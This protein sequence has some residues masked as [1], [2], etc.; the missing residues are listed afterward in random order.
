MGT[1][2]TALT[3]DRRDVARELARQVV[4][5]TDDELEKRRFDQLASAHFR[6][7]WLW[8]AR[9]ANKFDPTGAAG[10]FLTPVVLAVATALLGAVSASVVARLERNLGT[11]R[12]HRRRAGEPAAEAGPLRTPERAGPDAAEL[13]RLWDI[14]LAAALD[15]QTPEDHARRVAD[16]MLAKFVQAVAG[17]S[18]S[19]SSSASSSTSAATPS[20]EAGAGAAAPPDA[21]ADGAPLPQVLR[22]DRATE[23]GAPTGER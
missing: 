9:G 18:S 5:S 11:L 16:A 1:A 4:L 21:S 10:E 17:A 2:Y 12:R 7:W 13:A 23:G 15:C 8:T 22:P 3:R 14:C 6:P 20:V 19:T